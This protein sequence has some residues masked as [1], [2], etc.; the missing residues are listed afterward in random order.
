M[1][2][3]RNNLFTSFVVRSVLF[4][5]PLVIIAVIVSLV[6]DVPEWIYG[7][8]L[9]LAI[10]FN[11]LNIFDKRDFSKRFEK[12]KASRAKKGTVPVN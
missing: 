5:V 6:I 3:I 1:K 12:K 10:I 4:L 8:W 9:L 2:K 11:I 7:V